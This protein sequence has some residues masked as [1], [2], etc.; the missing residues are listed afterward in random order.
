MLSCIQDALQQRLNFWKNAQSNKRQLDLVSW[1]GF[2]GLFL[3]IFFAL[4]SFLF[5][6]R[7]KCRANLRGC[8][9]A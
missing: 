3:L 8:V 1:F 4:F 9:S 2:F 5:V 6:L 7:G